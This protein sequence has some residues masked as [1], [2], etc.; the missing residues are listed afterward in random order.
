MKIRGG[1]FEIGIE[2]GRIR[3]STANNE[4]SKFVKSARK[5]AGE[6]RKIFDDDNSFNEYLNVLSAMSVADQTMS[7][8]RLQRNM[9]LK[10]MQYDSFFSAGHFSLAMTESAPGRALR[11]AASAVGL[12]FPSVAPGLD[13]I[14]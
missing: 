13:R 8:R 1:L 9:R 4:I 6:Q 5:T 2:S 10:M 14:Q 12:V 11:S 3:A 7:T